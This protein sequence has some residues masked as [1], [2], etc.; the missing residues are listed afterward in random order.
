MMGRYLLVAHIVPFILAKSEV[1]EI[2]ETPLL[3][4]VEWSPSTG[5]SMSKGSLTKKATTVAWGNFTNAINQTGWSF[6]EVETDASFP[7]EIQ[8]HAAGYLEG[9][10]T[11]KLIYWHWINNMRTYCQDKEELCQRIVK[12]VHANTLWI[13]SMVEK[14]RKA[15]AYWH[16][17][18]LSYDQYN[19]LVAGYNSSTD[20]D[21]IPHGHLFWLNLFG[22]II[23]LEQAYTYKYN[24]TNDHQKGDGHCSVLIK[25][26]PNAND[27]LLAHDTWLKYSAMLRVLKKYTLGY[28]MSGR[29]GSKAIPGRSMTFSSYPATLFSADDFFTISSGLAVTETTN[30][31]FNPK[32]WQY[33]RPK[34]QILNFA[35]VMVANRLATNG[36][37]WTKIYAKHNSGTYNNQWMVVDYKRFKPGRKLRSGL[38]WILEQFP[39][40]IHAEDMTKVLEKQSYWSS[41]NVP[42]FS[43]MYNLSHFEEQRR[44]Y[45][46][47]FSHD[48]TPR[49]LIFK[50]D[51]P[52]VVDL[53]SAIRLMRSNN[54]KTD[55]LS[56][57][58]E[59]DPP[60][61]AE[62]AI[63][64]RNDLN[65][66]NGT[67]PLSIFGEGCAGGY[68][69]KITNKDMFEKLEFIAQ[70]GPTFD[71][72]P[73]FQWSKSDFDFLV[74]HVGQPDLW[75][76]APIHHIWKLPTLARSP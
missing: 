58:A 75:N 44:K 62:Y 68:D 51:Q 34:G 43:N 59:C 60:Y 26:L 22:D 30:E 61:N 18:G 67:Y 25:V 74:S 33:V 27:L 57:C 45:G 35:R 12:H 54:Y 17:V 6:F 32:L 73:P 56:I 48:Q 76:F 53:K 23:D 42:F 70:S 8:A 10:L 71:S 2:P 9:Q 65:E 50:R 4:T 24:L 15:R 52:Q 46:N 16:Q 41:Y 28:K 3:A 37:H 14:K 5:F 11:S 69:M 38:L 66:R 31:N 20:T 40:H 49:A 36:K 63:S 72:L 1:P 19:G 47:F 55:P 21:I 29:P 13:Q 39:G 7:D 64:A